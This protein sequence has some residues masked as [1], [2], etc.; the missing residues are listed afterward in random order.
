MD[1]NT[2]VILVS[3][4]SVLIVALILMRRDDRGLN[5]TSFESI[6]ILGLVVFVIFIFIEFPYSSNDKIDSSSNS[7]VVETVCE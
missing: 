7:K 6:Y 2:V 1:K 4:I 3:F 5:K